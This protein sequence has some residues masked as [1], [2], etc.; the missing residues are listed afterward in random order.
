MYSLLSKHPPYVLSSL[1]LKFQVPSSAWNKILNSRP[2]P[3]LGR[4][5]A[6]AAPAA[7]AALAARAQRLWP[8]HVGVPYMDSPSAGW[9]V[10]FKE[11]LKITGMIWGSPY[12]YIYLLDMR[13][14]E[15]GQSLSSPLPAP[16][17]IIFL[18]HFWVSCGKKRRQ[19]LNSRGE[20]GDS[21]SK[22]RTLL[23]I[24]Q[25]GGFNHL[26]KY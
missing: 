23:G 12:I 13:K 24:N 5:A 1:T 18:K 15:M 19:S 21:P 4:C 9:M 20:N 22:S 17:W 2:P 3:A 10:Y 26:E 8:V 16:S 6:A 25:V 7:R 14:Q 11:N